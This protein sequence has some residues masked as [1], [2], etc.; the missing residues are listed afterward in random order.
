M[1]VPTA[2]RF[3]A[4]ALVTALGACGGGGTDP[5]PTPS[6]SSNPNLPAVPLGLAPAA[7][8]EAPT[9][10][11]TFTVQNASGYDAGQ[12]QYTFEVVTA[13][14]GRVVV[15]GTVPAGSGTTSF[16]P[17][18]PLPRAS[19][20]V[21]T[22]SAR[23]AAGATA[24]SARVAFR[25]RAVECAPSGN[26]FAKSVVDW[27]LDA[28]SLARNRFKNPDEVLGPPNSS[29]NSPN[30]TGFMSLGEKGY[31]TVDME[32]CATD[33]DGADLRVWQRAS[34]EPVTL[35]ASG[36]PDGPFVLLGD[37]VRCG[38]LVP[39]FRSGYCDFNLGEGEMQDA[40][41]FKIEDGEIYPC[42]QAGTD[43]EGA[44]VDAIEILN[45]KR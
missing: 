42:P 44:D 14:K 22:A 33:G 28:C 37:R 4:I 24:V 21:W 39:G 2:S 36:R 13:G 32:I 16:T 5:S 30:F 15:R 45:R 17:P 38:T 26:R 18:G 40:R 3:W 41:Y 6:S 20:L 34:D 7:A 10:T 1:T 25:T 19:Q 12:A 9:D 43:T 29:G 31:V 35:Y 23:N 8:S 27:F 11:P